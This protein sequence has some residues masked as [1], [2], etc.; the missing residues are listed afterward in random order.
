MNT[1]SAYGVLYFLFMLAVVLAAAYYVT[2]YLSGKGL[3]KGK[4]KNLK[5]VETLPLGFDKSLLLVKAGEQY[6]LLGSTQ[7]NIS[8]IS[9]I[10]Q[11]KLAMESSSEVYDNLD[12]AGIESYIDKLGSRDAGI[13]TIKQNLIK[14][15]SIVRGNKIDV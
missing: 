6:L 5:V 11:E 9:V 13:N 15:K 2:R 10:D 14:L 8:F 12:D 4:N 7:K 3:K 1:N